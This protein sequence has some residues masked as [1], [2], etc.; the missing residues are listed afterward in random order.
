MI[1]YEMG[2]VS[3]RGIRSMTEAWQHCD[4]EYLGQ[5]PS[6]DHGQQHPGMTVTHWSHHSITRKDLNPS[7]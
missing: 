6:F 7:E 5:G 3:Q 1:N 2:K 4:L